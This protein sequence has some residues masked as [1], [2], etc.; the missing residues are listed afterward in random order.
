MPQIVFRTWLWKTG[1]TKD[2]VAQG[3]PTGS[4][5][6]I[7]QAIDLEARHLLLG[8][9]LMVVRPPT[10]ISEV[11]DWA[12]PFTP[13]TVRNHGGANGGSSCRLQCAIREQCREMVTGDGI[14]LSGAA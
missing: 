10:C 14:P 9:C 13:M 11:G 4:S 5:M 12:L 6:A 7:G 8:Q 1:V 2:L 3:F